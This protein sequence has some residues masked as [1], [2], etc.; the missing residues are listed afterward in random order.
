MFELTYFFVVF[1]LFVFLPGFCGRVRCSPA[2]HFDGFFKVCEVVSCKSGD[3][4][5]EGFEGLFGCRFPA[6]Q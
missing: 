2:D 5:A 6:F 1:I 3:S 4:G